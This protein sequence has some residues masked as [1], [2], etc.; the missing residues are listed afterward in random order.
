MS[1][2]FLND[3]PDIV[4]SAMRAVLRGMVPTLP[5]PLI[6]SDEKGNAAVSWLRQACMHVMATRLGA[7]L[8]ETGKAF[9]RDRTTARHAVQL[10]EAAIEENAD[11]A[12][13]IDFIEQCARARL[14]GVEAEELSTGYLP[15]EARR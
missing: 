14:A 1:A 7:T 12:A 9:G 3:R 10:V 5:T 6:F 4:G 13:F 15:S 8:S 2:A 11:T